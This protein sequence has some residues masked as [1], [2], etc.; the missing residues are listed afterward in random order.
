[1]SYGDGVLLYPGTPA[2]IGG[3][4]D[5]PIASLRLKMI[6]EGREDYEYLKLLVDRGDPKLARA[7][8]QRIAGRARQ[9][10]SDPAAL[11]DARRRAAERIVELGGGGAPSGS[12]H[13]N[14][15]QMRPVGSR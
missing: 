9:V 8:S 4:H 15:C 14:G 1:G 2:R 7:L 11:D 5:I 3:V 13:S 10:T 12:A 6:R